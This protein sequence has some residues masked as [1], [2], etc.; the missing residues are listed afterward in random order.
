VRYIDNGGDI[1]ESVDDDR[2]RVIEIGGDDVDDSEPCAIDHAERRWGPLTPVTELAD[3]EDY[4]P[5]L[6]TVSD[7]MDRASVFQNAHALVSGLK[8]S[9]DATVYDVLQVAKW[10]EGEG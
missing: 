4:T 9:D 8:W 5:P 7:V 3:E 10:L 2:V 1:W 6:P